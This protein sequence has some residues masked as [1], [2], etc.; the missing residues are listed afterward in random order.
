MVGLAGL[1]EPG[2]EQR[3]A[4]GDAGPDEGG[5]LLSFAVVQVGADGAGDG[6]Q[7]GD[8]LVPGAGGQRPVPECFAPPPVVDMA[9]ALLNGPTYCF[10]LAPPGLG[11]G[12]VV[13]L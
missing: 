10:D 3:L 1:D 11:R 12:G 6:R 4:S 9:V 8:D 5:C 13:T 7:A 2:S